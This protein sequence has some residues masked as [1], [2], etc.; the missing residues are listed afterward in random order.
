MTILKAW[1]VEEAEMGDGSIAHR[2]TMMEFDN[3]TGSWVRPDDRLTTA[4]KNTWNVVMTRA[5]DVQGQDIR[6]MVHPVSLMDFC[7]DREINRI[8]H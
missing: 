7:N 5:Q 4:G 8:K 2:Q 6:H 3:T 1:F